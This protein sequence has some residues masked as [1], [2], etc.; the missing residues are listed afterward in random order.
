MKSLHWLL[1]FVSP[2]LAIPSISPRQS[3]LDTWL[4]QEEEISRTAILNNIGA[5]GAWV[6]GARAGVV[7]ASPSRS[8]PDCMLCRLYF[9]QSLLPPWPLSKQP[10]TKNI[11]FYTWTRDS[12][13][14]LKTLIDL[15][16]AGDTALLPTIEQF[17]TS[18]AR[19]QGVSN[20]S[21]DLASGAGL[22]EA[23]FNADES[24]FTGGWGRPQRDGPALRATALVA[25][26]EWL[27]VCSFPMTFHLLWISSSWSFLQKER[28]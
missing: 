23:K 22:G 1:A 4:A 6:P 12:G 15:F 25:F 11:D 21:G 2:S 16:R 3:S 20:P 28:G 17:V 18:Q 9:L 24:A 13:L 27:V 14:V 7:I 19:I 26:G 5:D 10:L 8:D